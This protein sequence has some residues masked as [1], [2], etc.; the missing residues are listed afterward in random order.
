MCIRVEG[1]E[2]KACFNTSIRVLRIRKDRTSPFVDPILIPE[3]PYKFPKIGDIMGG[4]AFFAFCRFI[5]HTIGEYMGGLWKWR[6]HQDA[7]STIALFALCV[8]LVRRGS[9]PR[10]DELTSS[11]DFSDRCTHFCPSE[12]FL[13]LFCGRCEVSFDPPL[14]ESLNR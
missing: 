9:K 4:L 1:Y 13:R 8:L 7:L 5:E 6:L 3:E 10:Q 2:I 12:F 11:C 14:D